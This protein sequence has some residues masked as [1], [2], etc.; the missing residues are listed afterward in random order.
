MKQHFRG[1]CVWITVLQT[2]L[3]YSNTYLKG[4]YQAVMARPCPINFGDMSYKEMVETIQKLLTGKRY[5]VVLDDVWNVNTMGIVNLEKA[6][7]RDKPGSRIILT[8]R[9]MNH[10]YSLFEVQSLHFHNIEP[11]GGEKA[12]QL[13]CN[14]AFPLLERYS[15][16][17]EIEPIARDLAKK[18][19]GLPL[20]LV[21]LGGLMS[22]KR[23]FNDWFRV[24]KNLNWEL[25][26]NQKVEVI[27][28]I[29]LLRYHDLPH[30]LKQCFLY[31]CIFPEDYLIQR[32]RLIRLWIAEGFVELQNSGTTLEETVAG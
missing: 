4:L 2:T 22:T 1:C 28:K 8:T 14:K 25:S 6:F 11:L 26:S 7:P 32:G 13:F 24:L 30:H 29:L 20:G 19:G 16:P 23:E 17:A 5:L 31:C 10:G 12:W 15:C 9:E 27:N 21:A 18:C 3:T